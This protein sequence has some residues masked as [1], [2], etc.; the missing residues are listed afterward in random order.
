MSPM[1]LIKICNPSRK[2]DMNLQSKDRTITM[3]DRDA[4]S[5]RQMCIRICCIVALASVCPHSDAAPLHEA[6]VVKQPSILFI[7][8][9]DLGFGDV[10]CLNAKSK[11]HT[12]NID[13]LANEGVSFTDAHTA[14]PICGPSRYGL[15]TGRYPWRKGPDGAG[16]GATFSDMRIEQGRLTIPAMLGRIGYNTAQIGKW[17]LRH[18]YRD[19]LKAGVTFRSEL[20]EDAFDFSHKRLLGAELVGFQH[21]WSLVHLSPNKN[22]KYAFENGLPVDPDLSDYDAHHWLP[23]GTNQALDYLNVYAGKFSDD[24]FQIDRDLP[25]FV[26]WDPHVPHLPIVPNDEFLGRSGAGR[27]GDFVVELDHRVG[28]LLDALDEL[29]LAENTIVFFSSDNGPENPA[30]EHIKEFDHYSMGDFRGVK[31]DMWEGGHREPF[32]VRWPKRIQAHRVVDA[33]ICLTDVIATLA[34]LLD[35]S[36]PSDSAEDSI[37]FLPLLLGESRPNTVRAPIVH[38]K[39]A[40]FAIRSGD[41]VYIDSDHQAHA[42]E[43][44]WF[45]DKRGV[46]EDSSG[47]ALYNLA[48]DPEETRNLAS[49]MPEKVKELQSELTRLREGNGSR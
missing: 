23:D 1:L 13:R 36:L 30:Y 35:Y 43:P 16:N 39:G 25:F 44:Q 33:P 26:Y 6:E 12:P 46:V 49:E 22:R 11:I 9:D 47:V 5:I 18:N 28:Q 15:L 10:S 40:N 27:Y 8:C 37:S 45:R 48:D 31:R 19:A 32:L 4:L 29:E 38:H 17:G 14:A 21:T 42:S 20:D 7:Y 41:W 34:D 2:Y 3:N 24:R